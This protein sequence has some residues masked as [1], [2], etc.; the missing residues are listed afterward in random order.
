[1]ILAWFCTR[2]LDKIHFMALSSVHLTR[3]GTLPHLCTIPTSASYLPA[4]PTDGVVM[5]VSAQVSDAKERRRSLALQVL[6][7]QV[8]CQ[9][10]YDY[11]GRVCTPTDFHDAVAATQG[12][13]L[14]WLDL[15]GDEQLAPTLQAV[16]QAAIAAADRPCGRRHGPHARRRGPAGS[17]LPRARW[18]RLYLR[19]L[20]A[21]P[22]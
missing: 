11:V 14:L 20:P 9:S 2:D 10:K 6:M 8:G 16:S 1:M 21:A 7:T 4:A 5:I 22:T 19:G 15:S 13:K 3:F 12:P 17:T 18:S